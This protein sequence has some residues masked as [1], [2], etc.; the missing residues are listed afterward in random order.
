MPFDPIAGRCSAAHAEWLRRLRDRNLYKSR[1]SDWDDFCRKNVG[2][3]GA[4]ATHNIELLEEFGA[5]Y[6]KLAE[7]TRITPEEF[8]AVASKLKGN[9]LCV[10]GRAIELLPENAARIAAAMEKLRRPRPVR[11]RNWRY[12]SSNNR[13]TL[14]EK[15]CREV[16]VEFR[17]LAKP[18]APDVDRLQ[19]ASVLRKTLSMLGRIEMELGIY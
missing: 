17:K 8:R 1:S 16:T 9:Y 5:N 18:K 6:F 4:D 19:L 7:L 12:P 2:M 11:T 15:S 3:S 10:N 14:L 13:V